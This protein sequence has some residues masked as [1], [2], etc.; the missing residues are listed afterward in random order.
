MLLEVTVV[1]LLV[2]LE[3][4][5]GEILGSRSSVLTVRLVL[6]PARYEQAPR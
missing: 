2:L 4:S 5:G 3:A 1:V 6:V